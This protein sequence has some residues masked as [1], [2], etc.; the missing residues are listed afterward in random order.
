MSENKTV[1]KVQDAWGLAGDLKVFLFSKEAPWLGQLTTA[2]LAV[3]ESGVVKTFQVKSK[4]FER[5]F[6]KI[7]LEG[8]AD[9]TQAE[10]WISAEFQISEE[11]LTSKKGE[12]VFLREMIGFTVTS[13]NVQLG[14]VVGFSSNGAQDLI[15]IKHLQGF[16]FEAP[17]V[18]AFLLG[19]DFDNKIIQMDLPEGLWGEE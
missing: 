2:T 4:K 9:R 10:K 12:R 17:F 7:K 16:D 11:L 6:L 15:V 1:G 14:Q 3:Q 13:K 19:I 18:E 8:I 5:D